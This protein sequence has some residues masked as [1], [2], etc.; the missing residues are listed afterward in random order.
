MCVRVSARAIRG[1]VRA[2]ADGCECERLGACVRV[3]AHAYSRACQCG[4]GRVWD[5]SVSAWVRACACVRMRIRV[6]AGAR[7]IAD[8][9]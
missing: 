1:D 9:S 2:I 3:G 5:A 8:E 4:C 6:R 7:A